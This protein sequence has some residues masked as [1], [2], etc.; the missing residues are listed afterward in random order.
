MKESYREWSEELFFERPNRSIF[1]GN[2]TISFVTNCDH[3][4]KGI[5]ILLHPAS[6][7]P[8]VF[9]ANCGTWIATLKQWHEWDQEHR[10]IYKDPFRPK[11]QLSFSTSDKC[12][13]SFWDLDL[14]EFQ[15]VEITFLDPPIKKVR[16]LFRNLGKKITKAMRE[17]E[18]RIVYVPKP[19]LNPAFWY[20]IEKKFGKQ[21]NKEKKK[22]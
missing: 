8:C 14:N 2:G 11:I 1:Q 10:D 15:F 9:C 19:F 18:Q 7:T 20:E 12:L 3:I 17:N 6:K 22:E 5:A 16:G 4:V 13:R 21:M